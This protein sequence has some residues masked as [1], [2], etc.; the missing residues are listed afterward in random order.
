[1]DEKKFLKL[2][3]LASDFDYYLNNNLLYQIPNFLEKFLYKFRCN[4]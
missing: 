1:M 4:N 3:D 2:N